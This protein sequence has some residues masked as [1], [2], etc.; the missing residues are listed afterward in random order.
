MRWEVYYEFL[1]SRDCPDIFEC[2]NVGDGGGTGGGCSDGAV[3]TLTP[4]LDRSKI[5][6]S[7]A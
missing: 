3:R 7:C 2:G 1:V 5:H 4:A 6:T